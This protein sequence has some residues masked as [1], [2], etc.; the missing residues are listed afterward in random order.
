MMVWYPKEYK[1]KW[2]SQME[3]LLF[4]TRQIQITNKKQIFNRENN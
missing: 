2:N 3:E 4:E 1:M